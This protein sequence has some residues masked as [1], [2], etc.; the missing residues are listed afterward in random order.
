MV[1]ASI[2]KKKKK[3]QYKKG[4]FKHDKNVR[5]CKGKEKIG[6]VTILKKRKEE[7]K[8]QQTPAKGD[9]DGGKKTVFFEGE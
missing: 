9:T 6:Y 5:Y 4:G 8:V 2:K 7:T 3:R 1:L